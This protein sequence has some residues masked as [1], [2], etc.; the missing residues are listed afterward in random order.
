MANGEGKGQ[1]G[2][3][4]TGAAMSFQPCRG[5]EKCTRLRYVIY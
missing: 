4:Y 3:D 2:A 5:E 1:R